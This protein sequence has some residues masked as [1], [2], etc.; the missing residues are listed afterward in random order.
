MNEL[1]IFRYMA[2]SLR[3]ACV[4]FN[5]L[6]ALV[7]KIFSGATRVESG[8][9][10]LALLAGGNCLLTDKWIVLVLRANLVNCDK[11]KE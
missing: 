9:Y 2:Q 6:P 10:L 1:I 3:F 8:N 11:V 5:T 4:F 7:N